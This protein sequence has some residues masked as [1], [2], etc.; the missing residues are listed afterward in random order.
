[1]TGA[2]RAEPL[3]RPARPCRDRFSDAAGQNSTPPAR[4][5][6]PKDFDLSV[7][8]AMSGAAIPL[9]RR[10]RVCFDKVA[11]SGSPPCN[12]DQEHA[13]APYLKRLP[14]STATRCHAAYSRRLGSGNFDP[15]T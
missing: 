11:R 10:A 12:V 7:A 13:A 4:L 14:A 8:L 15:A 6:D 9:S 1:V 3:S 5:L 2:H